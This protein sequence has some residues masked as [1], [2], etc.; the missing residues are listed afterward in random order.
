MYIS[1]FRTEFNEYIEKEVA[2]AISF[3]DEIFKVIYYYISKKKN[4]IRQKN[5]DFHEKI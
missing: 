2:E 5:N 4:N 1:I 3:L